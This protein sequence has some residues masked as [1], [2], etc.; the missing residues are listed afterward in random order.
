VIPD[1]TA[2][3]GQKIIVDTAFHQRI[4]KT[5]TGRRI[6]HN[7][8]EVETAKQHEIQPHFQS[9]RQLRGATARSADT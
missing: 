3:T 4:A 6:G 1:L 5:A 7:C 2:N 8:K 9:L